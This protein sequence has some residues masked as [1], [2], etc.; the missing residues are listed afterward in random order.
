MKD[1]QRVKAFGLLL[2]VLGGA[3]AAT[4]DDAYSNIAGF[5]SRPCAGEA[6]TWLSV[7][8]EREMR[9]K[10]ALRVEGE[11]PED[12]RVL[13]TVSVGGLGGLAPG[14]MAGQA[15]VR[16]VQGALSGRVSN[17]VENGASSLTVDFRGVSPSPGTAVA[18]SLA[19]TLDTLFPPATQSTFHEST[20]HFRHQR[21]SELL[22]MN[23]G[24]PGE[25][26]SAQRVFYIEGGRWVEAGSESSEAGRV[27][28]A[29]D[30]VIVVRHPEGV[31]ETEFVVA[32]TAFQGPV[33]SLV[34]SI[35]GRE[36]T[37]AIGLLVTKETR[38]DQLGLNAA[39]FV[40][41][42][43]RGYSGRRDTLSVYSGSS[44][45]N[46]KPT[47]VY[48]RYRGNWR[49]VV[50]GTPGANAETIPP[51]SPVVIHR[52]PVRAPRDLWWKHP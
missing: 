46:P 43:K 11:T 22:V 16:P 48:F 28:L 33:A 47:G 38:L 45:W 44:G 39:L 27:S 23:A 21:G 25:T 52:A 12:G 2:A 30:V 15:T 50:P 37:Q 18:V 42:S 34:R 36:Y 40:N 49:K 6:D 26:I 4:G 24:A 14:E 9:V 29:P 41:S 1:I 19:W 51:G 3:A 10:G 35:R 8:F 20:G 13:T 32:G 5:I 17:V 31:T 7:P